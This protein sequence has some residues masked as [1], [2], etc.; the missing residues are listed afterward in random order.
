M[1][2]RRRLPIRVELIVI[3]GLAVL[4]WYFGLGPPDAGGHVLAFP[5]R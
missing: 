4:A 2:T 1:T 5:K 3:A